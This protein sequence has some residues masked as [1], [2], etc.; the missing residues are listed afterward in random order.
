MAIAIR[1]VNSQ[2]Q[3]SRLIDSFRPKGS[4]ENWLGKE[5]CVVRDMGQDRLCAN[6]GAEKWEK[7]AP[8]EGW[9]KTAGGGA[10]NQFDM[11]DH[12]ECLPS[13]PNYPQ[14]IAREQLTPASKL[15]FVINQ[16]PN[17]CW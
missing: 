7:V 1:L 10:K 2:A 13:A 5:K 15:V 14:F 3:G 11:P 8:C 12:C 17:A 4:G 16:K 9:Q 6:I